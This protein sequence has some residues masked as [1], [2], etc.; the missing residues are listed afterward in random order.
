MPWPPA[1][2]GGYHFHCPQVPGT[3]PGLLEPAASPA[4]LPPGAGYLPKPVA[5]R[6]GEKNF[7]AL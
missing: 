4:F 2:E 7:F 5:R 1:H 6:R 3:L